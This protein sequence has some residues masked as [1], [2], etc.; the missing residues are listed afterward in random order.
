M[1]KLRVPLDLLM[2]KIGRLKIDV[3]W[4]RLSSKPV[5]IEIDSV[6]I[7]V[8]PKGQDEWVDNV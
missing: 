6:Y 8:T 3:P 1:D 4:N 2:G 5:E 7:V